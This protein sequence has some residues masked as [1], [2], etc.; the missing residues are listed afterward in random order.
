MGNFTAVSGTGE[1]GVTGEG[2]SS[3]F[4]SDFTSDFASDFTSATA[5]GT[6]ATVGYFT[7]DFTSSTGTV[8][9]VGGK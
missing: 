7:S 2:F 1:L 3:D 6:V 8:V 9:T 4:T 5:A